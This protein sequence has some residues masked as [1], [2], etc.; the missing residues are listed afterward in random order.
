MPSMETTTETEMRRSFRTSLDWEREEYHPCNKHLPKRLDYC[1]KDGKYYCS[2]IYSGYRFDTDNKQRL[3]AKKILAVIFE[4]SHEDP[5]VIQ[6]QLHDKLGDELAL[7]P[8]IRSI[9]KSLVLKGT[10]K[11]VA[12]SER[13]Y[14]VYP[15]FECGILDWMAEE[16]AKFLK[17]VK[18]GKATYEDWYSGHRKTNILMFA[19]FLL[20]LIQKKKRFIHGNLPYGIAVKKSS[21]LNKDGEQVCIERV[22]ACNAT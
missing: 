10:T 18:S 21:V 12:N 13:F 20:M 9:C 8:A 3:I 11:F 4:Y 2:H 6:R 16:R 5:L 15:G 17:S 19:K 1:D 7:D 22:R 14:V